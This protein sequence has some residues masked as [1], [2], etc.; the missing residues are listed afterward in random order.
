MVFEHSGSAPSS[1]RSPRFRYARFS[2]EVSERGQG[3]FDPEVFQFVVSS[4]PRAMDRQGLGRGRGPAWSSMDADGAI[5]MEMQPYRQTSPPRA[6]D[7]GHRPTAAAHSTR[8]SDIFSTRL[9]TFG[10]IPRRGPGTPPGRAPRHKINRQLNSQL[11]RC[12]P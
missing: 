11:R 5:G 9:K 2:P 10:G 1:W 4:L 7:S 12:W 3:V 6:P 8:R